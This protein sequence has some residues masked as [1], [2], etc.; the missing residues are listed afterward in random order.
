MQQVQSDGTQTDDFLLTFL[1]CFFVQVA[2]PDVKEA[3]KGAHILIFVLPH[4]FVERICL[5]IKDCVEKDAMAISL[6]KVIF[7]IRG[8]FI[9]PNSLGLC[10][11]KHTEP[12]KPQQIHVHM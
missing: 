1:V 4:Q 9:K 5:Q 2:I 11:G 10:T 8:M 12:H 7:A 3:V 6:I